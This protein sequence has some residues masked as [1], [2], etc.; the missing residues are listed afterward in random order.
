LDVAGNLVYL[1][2]RSDF[3]DQ[4]LDI[5]RFTY[6][7]TIAWDL[8]AY[9]RT[10]RSPLMLTATASSG[11][12]V[13]Y[14]LLSGPAILSDNTLAFTGLGPVRIRAMQPGN[15]LYE[16]A[17][18]ERTMTVLDPSALFL[19]ISTKPSQQVEIALDG[20]P[21]ASVQLEAAE[22]LGLAAQWRVLLHTNPATGF[23]L[24][25]D[26]DA[27]SGQRFYRLRQP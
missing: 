23:F 1:P 4:G 13:S 14:E 19:G 11:L 6:Q 12:P 3:F 26:T 17:V 15:E 24:F 18:V 21:G 5:Y 10:N 27:Q 2:E 16:P 22:R 9:T 20:P 25:V 8:P 7:Q